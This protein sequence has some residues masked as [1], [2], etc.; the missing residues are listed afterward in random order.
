MAW[1]SK[2]C[3][4]SPASSTEATV[5]GVTSLGGALGGGRFTT[6]II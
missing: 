5:F 3:T 1:S 6:I 2:L 4:Q